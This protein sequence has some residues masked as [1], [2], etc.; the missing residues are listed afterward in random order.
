MN[1]PPKTPVG[2]RV[3]RLTAPPMVFLPYSVPCGPRSTSMRSRS[4]V[5]K[6]APVDLAIGTPSI[7]MPTGWSR[8]RLV[9]A[10][11]ARPRIEISG[12]KAPPTV[13]LI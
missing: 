12:P 7:Y 13:W 11:G 5:S 2:C 8:P 10:E 9:S 3:T 6:A 1:L 4:T